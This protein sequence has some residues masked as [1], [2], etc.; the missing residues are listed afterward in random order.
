MVRLVLAGP[1]RHHHLNR[2]DFGIVSEVTV[3]TKYLP[4][5]LLAYSTNEHVDGCGSNP[6]FTANVAHTSRIL[7]VVRCQHYI[8]IFVQL[9]ADF[10]EFCLLANSGEYLLADRSK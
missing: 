7:I 8:F 2:Q 4:G 3:G 1:E 9:I 10:E 5:S 6:R